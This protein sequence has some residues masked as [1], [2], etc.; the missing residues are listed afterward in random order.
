M[1]GYLQVLQVLPSEASNSHQ[2][3]LPVLIT[4]QDELLQ[5]LTQPSGQDERVGTL[6]KQRLDENPAVVVV[7]YG[8]HPHDA[9][10]G[11]SVMGGKVLNEFQVHLQKMKF[12]EITC[13]QMIDSS[14]KDISFSLTPKIIQLLLFFLIIVVKHSCFVFFFFQM[15]S[16]NSLFIDPLSI[17]V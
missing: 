6:V 9:A 15:A 16:M 17:E 13:F 14:W 1:L 8:V 10:Q 11:F 3:L 5:V 12:I 7:T 4:V 2:V